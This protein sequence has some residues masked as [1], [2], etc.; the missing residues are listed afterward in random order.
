MKNI[1]ICL[2]II[3]GGYATSFG[4]ISVVNNICTGYN[5]SL[6]GSE[7]TAES[8]CNYNI[9]A[10]SLMETG[11]VL[12]VESEV[13]FGALNGVSTLDLVLITQGILF[14]FD[15]SEDIFLSD[16]NQNGVVST[17]DL[18]NLRRMIL[19]M[20]DGANY[21]HYYVTAADYEFPEL[22]PFEFSLDLSNYIFDETD[23]VDNSL[24]VNVIKLG[25]INSN[26][27]FDSEDDVST[28]ESYSI[29]Y[30]NIYI[31]AGQTYHI[32][33]SINNEQGVMGCLFSLQST[34]LEFL[35]IQSDFTG[36][37]LMY[38]ADLDNLNVSYLNIEGSSVL[39]FTVELYAKESGYL[40]EHLSLNTD[41]PS[42]IVDTNNEEFKLE[43]GAL[44]TSVE[45]KL[46]TVQSVYPNP[47]LDNIHIEFSGEGAKSISLF[48]EQ[49][50]LIWLDET[51]KNNY[52]L[53]RNAFILSGTYILKVD[54]EKTSEVLKVIFN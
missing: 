30:N 31:E 3:F 18:V 37:K 50:Q 13:F 54:S 39:N 44:S 17:Y 22:D 2:V 45:E 53:Q 14:G 5:M 46:H 32:P 51:S 24:N 6:N 20:D 34:G 35:G 40:G 9:F 38:K 43:L 42:D 16:I 41:F 28:R 33:F 8:N 52:V 10:S 47:A 1:F 25:D 23:I 19:G 48:N 21:K 7:L 11:N 15:N 26:A 36:D 49:G 29:G 27:T 4:Q 12:E